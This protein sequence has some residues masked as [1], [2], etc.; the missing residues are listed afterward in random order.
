MDREQHEALET[1]ARGAQRCRRCRLGETRNRAVPGEGAFRERVVLLGEAPGEMEDRTGR[2]F[3]GRTGV[4]LDAFLETHGFHREDFFITPA[5]KCR[6]PRNRNP[7]LDELTICREAWLARQ[8]QALSPRFV[9]VTGKIPARQVLGLRDALHVLRGAP[10]DLPEALGGFPALVTCH[11]TAAMR[12][13]QQRD[14][15]AT[16]LGRLRRLLDHG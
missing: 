8:L 1:L 6:P 5:V 13:P 7:R 10:H 2:P 4:F 9:L 12:F 14:A 15:M 3:V 11:P 16:D